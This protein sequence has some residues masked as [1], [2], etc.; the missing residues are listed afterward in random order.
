MDKR[1][2]EKIEQ[3]G[4]IEEEMRKFIRWCLDVVFPASQAD[5]DDVELGLDDY[6]LSDTH[7]FLP[8]TGYWSDGSLKSADEYGVCWSS[9][10]KG[11]NYAI[12]IAFNFSSGGWG[13]VPLFSRCTGLSVRAVCE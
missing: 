4:R 2:Q 10:N 5:S 8:I 13:F 7:I 12:A 6:S 9:L 3:A 1:P 11:D